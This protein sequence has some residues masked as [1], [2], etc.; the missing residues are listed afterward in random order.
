M[1]KNKPISSV[2]VNEL[3]ASFSLDYNYDPSDYAHELAT[4]IHIWEE[5]GYVEIYQTIQDRDYGKIKSSEEDGNGNFIYQYCD[6]YHARVSTNGHDP[7]VVV[8]FHEDDE[9]S[10][11]EYVSLRFLS[12]HEQL[13][14]S[15]NQKANR[16]KLKIIRDRADTK[17]QEGDST[18]S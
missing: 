3:F 7:L 1:P 17:I 13:F 16:A 8:K 6:L 2:K 4:L 15:V 11:T 10:E 12:D 14:G 5:Q 9:D 18:E